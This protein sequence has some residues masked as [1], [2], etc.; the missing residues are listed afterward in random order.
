[1][2]AIDLTKIIKKY[3]NKWVALSSDNKKFIGSA[4][5]LNQVLTLANTKGVK[6]PTVFKA[7]EVKNL[8]I[9]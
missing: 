1:M 9:G 4:D 3:K 8:F 6:E 5:T 2:T 7:P